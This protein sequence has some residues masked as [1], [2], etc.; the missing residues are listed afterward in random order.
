[1]HPCVI[2]LVHIASVAVVVDT[3][4]LLQVQVMS[5]AEIGPSA[6]NATSTAVRTAGFKS[7]H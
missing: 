6:N 1:M 7:L 4:V 3:C 5:N 2:S